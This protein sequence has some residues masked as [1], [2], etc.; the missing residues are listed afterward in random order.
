MQNHEEIRLPFQVS[1]KWF[2]TNAS[3]KLKASWTL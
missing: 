3:F 1:Q 2:R